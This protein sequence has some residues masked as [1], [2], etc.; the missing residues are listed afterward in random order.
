MRGDWVKAATTLSGDC[1][2]LNISG[3]EEEVGEIAVKDQGKKTVNSG[4]EMEKGAFLGSDKQNTIL[5]SREA[6]DT[7][8]EMARL[9][10]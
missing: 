7:R 2:H 6:S 5:G 9:F 8:G 10:S 4:L 1:S 3:G